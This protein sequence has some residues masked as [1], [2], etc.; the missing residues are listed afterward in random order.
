LSKSEKNSLQ[1]FE[2]KWVCYASLAHLDA[3]LQTLTNSQ[4]NVNIKWK[5]NEKFNES[6]SFFDK[7]VANDKKK[8]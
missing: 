1:I 8:R 6:F 3:I 5:S 7:F 2:N 4:K